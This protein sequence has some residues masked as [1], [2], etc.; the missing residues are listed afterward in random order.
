MK[1]TQKFNYDNNRDWL[2]SMDQEKDFGYDCKQ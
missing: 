2:E 1:V